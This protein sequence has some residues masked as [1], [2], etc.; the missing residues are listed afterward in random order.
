MIKKLNNEEVYRF[1]RS[2]KVY[3][4]V[5]IHEKNTLSGNPTF[6]ALILDDSSH[7]MS[8]FKFHGHYLE[9]REEAKFIL[10][11]FLNEIVK[12]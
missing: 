12:G 7:V 10:D 2:G 8:P 11:Y 5:L 3:S 1:L 4:V 9:E 6:R